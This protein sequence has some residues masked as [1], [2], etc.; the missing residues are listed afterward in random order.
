LKGRDIIT[1]N[2]GNWVNKTY[3]SNWQK[4]DTKDNIGQKL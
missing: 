3:Q 1:I 4:S 2:D